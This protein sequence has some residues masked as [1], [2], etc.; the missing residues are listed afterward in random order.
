MKKLSF[1]IIFLFN[2]TLI[3]AQWESLNG[4]AGGY[5]RSIAYNGEVLYAATGGGVLASDDD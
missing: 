4:P 5:I 3:F 2:I 1:F